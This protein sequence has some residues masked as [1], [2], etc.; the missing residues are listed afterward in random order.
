MLVW[1]IACAP[2]RQL[3]GWLYGLLPGYDVHPSAGIG[4]L[5]LIDVESLSMSHDSRVGRGCRIVGPMRVELGAGASIGGRNQAECGRW[6]A[7]FDSAE[8]P[9]AR[10]F[11]LGANAMVTTDHYFDATGG[12][13]IGEGSWIAG[14]GS[15]FWT[16][17]LG[18]VDRSVEVGRY[19][20]VGSAVRFAPGARVGTLAVVGLGSVVTQDLSAHDQALIAGAPAAVVREN[21]RPAG[22]GALQ[23]AI[24]DG[25]VAYE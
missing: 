11:V 5:S 2:S 12:I 8:A 25:L 19:T 7:E 18:V 3:R 4:W 20:Y 17:G 24:A 21:Y 6:F 1:A 9:Y 15:Q 13:R 16:H 23:K 22:W 14:R 10:E